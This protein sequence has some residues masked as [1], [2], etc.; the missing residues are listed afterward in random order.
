MASRVVM[1]ST[2]IAVVIVSLRVGQT[3]LRSSA[4]TCRM[5]SPGVTFA[6]DVPSDLEQIEKG[7][8]R[9]AAGP[10]V[11]RA[12]RQAVMEVNPMTS[13][14]RSRS[15][16]GSQRPLAERRVA[17]YTPRSGWQGQGDSNPRPSVLETDALPTELYPYAEGRDSCEQA[18]R[19]RREGPS[20]FR[21][22]AAPFS[23]RRASGAQ[24]AISNGVISPD[25]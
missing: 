2:M 4:R 20:S 10:R 21:A 7:G 25:R 8:P 14:L 18:V 16:A 3:T 24:A 6:T 19:A 11:R 17:R 12:L 23:R 5:N 15:S 1:I 22:R 13:I 9:R